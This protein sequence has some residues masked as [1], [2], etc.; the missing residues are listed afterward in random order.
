MYKQ[1]TKDIVDTVAK[2]LSKNGYDDKKIK[3]KQYEELKTDLNKILK[4]CNPAAIPCTYPIPP[5]A[6]D[7]DCKIL[8]SD[9][10]EQEIR[11]VT[12]SACARFQF[13][14]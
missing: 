7:R 14:L 12:I 9:N 10:E 2:Y 1:E 11:A 13:L 6:K 5:L 3:K 8:F 4:A